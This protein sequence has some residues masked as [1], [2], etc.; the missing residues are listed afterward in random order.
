MKRRTLLQ[1]LGGTSFAALGGHAI[2]IEP[3]QLVVSEY[4]V[5]EGQG[6]GLKLLQISDLH[7]KKVGDF[8]RQL[9]AAINQQQ[10]DM[11]L[12]TGDILDR[13]TTLPALD[14]FLALLDRQPAKYA[15]LGNWENHSKVNLDGLRATYAQHE[16]QLLINESTVYRQGDRELLITGLDDTVEGWPDLVK[17]LRG[18]KPTANHLVLAHAPNQLDVWSEAER[19]LLDRFKPQLMLSGHTHGGQITVL[20]FAP[21]L[22]RG[23]GHYVKGWYR[24]QTPQLYVSRGLGGSGTTARLG[25]KPEIVVLDWALK[26]S[27]G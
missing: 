2:F 3:H 4:G 11:L 20:G 19:A 16:C 17:A 1:L 6:A 26:P 13:S 21:V 12:F 9:I 15:I 10:A 25:A 7:L 8:E 14:D 5:G 27:V 18:V 22:P 24:E 23:T